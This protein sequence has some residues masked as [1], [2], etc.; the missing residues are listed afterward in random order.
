MWLAYTCEFTLAHH[1]PVNYKANQLKIKK[2]IKREPLEATGKQKPESKDS[3]TF[4]TSYFWYKSKKW[5]PE[6]HK[7]D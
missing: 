2:P 5:F 3:T 7:A 1:M 4:S 6:G